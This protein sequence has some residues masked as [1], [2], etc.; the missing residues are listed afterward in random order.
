MPASL[1]L[2]LATKLLLVLSTSEGT[3][4][5]VQHHTE[6]TFHLGL[7]Y[8]HGWGVRQDKLLALR[9]LSLAAKVGHPLAMYNMAMLHLGPNPALPPSCPTA[10]DL[11][12]RVQISSHTPHTHTHTHTHTQGLHIITDHAQQVQGSIAPSRCHVR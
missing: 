4:F 10:L 12:K 9:H 6:S 3:C 7:M 2:K 8:L 11:L 1:V 5:P